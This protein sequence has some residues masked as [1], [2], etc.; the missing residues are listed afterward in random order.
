MAD[1]AQ[2]ITWPNATCEGDENAQ[3]S[4]GGLKAADSD[5]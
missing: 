2:I 3:T 1:L 4:C 5:Y